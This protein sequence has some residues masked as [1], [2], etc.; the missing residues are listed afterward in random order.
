MSQK[1]YVHNSRL[2]LGGPTPPSTPEQVIDVNFGVKVDPPLFKKF[3]MFNSGLVPLSRYRKDRNLINELKPESLRI[4][5]SIGKYTGKCFLYGMVTGTPD[6]LQYNFADIDKLAG[7]LNERNVLPYWSYCYIPR[8]LQKWG[9]W[10]RGPSDLNVWKEMHSAFASHFKQNNIRIGYQEIYNEPDLDVFYV[11]TWDEYLQMYKHGVEGLKEG[12][13]DAVVGGPAMAYPHKTTHINSFLDFVTQENL[14]LDFFSFHAYNNSHLTKL[15]KIRA[16]L[17]K[18]SRFDTTEIHMNELNVFSPW[19][20]R[21][22]PVDKYVLASQIFETIDLLLDQ[23]DLTLV[24][25]AEFQ[26]VRWAK[27]GIGIVNLRGKRK[28]AFNAFKIYAMMPVDRCQVNSNCYGVKGMASTD[29]HKAS[30]VIWNNSGTSKIPFVNLT[31]VPFSKGN[32]R[33]YRIDADHASYGDNPNNELLLPV[34]ENVDINMARLYWSGE[35]PPKGVVYLEA[36]DGTGI[37]ELDPVSVAKVIRK[38]HYYPDRSESCY[39]EFDENTWIARLGM[40]N[41]K[42]AHSLVGITVEEI[43]SVLKVSFVVEA[44]LQRL[45]ENS[46]LGMRID[47]EVNGKYTKSILFHGELYDSQRNATM[48]WGTKRLPDEVIQI[49]DLSNF[50]IDLISDAPANWSGRAIISFEMQ[51]TG[52]NTRAKVVVSTAS[53]S[54]PGCTPTSEST[55]HDGKI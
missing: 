14:A 19:V 46:L 37:S 5:L 49:Q 32:F 53:T 23:T 28:A 21:G 31:N 44:R 48:P 1:S 18:S 10:R 39:A 51:N 42:L 43:P 6:N 47:Y 41:E 26:E 40:G 30:V 13:P 9:D 4:D 33:V 22:G 11:G 54:T 27:S 55:S 35:I 16:C 34:E 52:A 7:L 45:D 50:E 38:H 20:K 25:W 2:T 29:G 8:P 15:Q 36:E 17:E 3:A 24:H 12:D